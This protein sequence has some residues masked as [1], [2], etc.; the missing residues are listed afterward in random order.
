MTKE[1]KIIGLILISGISYL[2]YVY[3]KKKGSNQNLSTIQGAEDIQGSG[4]L[5]ESAPSYLIYNFS[6]LFGTNK[7]LSS[8]IGT[9]S[10]EDGLLKSLPQQSFN[11][12]LTSSNDINNILSKLPPPSAPIVAPKVDFKPFESYLLESASSSLKSVGSFIL[13]EASKGVT[14]LSIAGIN[15]KPQSN[16]QNTQSATT[17]T[18][19]QDKVTAKD[20][21]SVIQKPLNVG[22]LITQEIAK[23]IKNIGLFK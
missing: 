16:N 12:T 10:Q 14:S 22:S 6:D 21:L 4:L 11:K 1:N 2:G 8:N 3:F 13:K 20:V 19:A 23:G 17:E 18:K 15:L 9:T 7:S 5:Q